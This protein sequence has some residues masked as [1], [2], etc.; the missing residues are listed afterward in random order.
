MPAAL[1]HPRFFS[2]SRAEP[3]RRGRLPDMTAQKPE[4][5]QPDHAPDGPA[6]HPV[7]RSNPAPGFRSSRNRL[8]T[9]A[10]LPDK[11][12]RGATSCCASIG[13]AGDPL[14][15]AA[16]EAA[17]ARPDSVSTDKR[18][19]L[20]RVQPWTRR[21]RRS[22]GSG[23]R[24]PGIPWSGMTTGPSAGRFD[25]RHRGRSNS[26]NGAAPRPAG[27]G[28]ARAMVMSS[29]RETMARD[30]AHPFPRGRP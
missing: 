29:D 14:G 19:C 23:T 13:S 22:A 28:N 1:A 12:R 8:P 26:D 7:A 27:K 25:G 6:H 2:H 9:R 4:P 5:D 15:R 3:P 11:A 10:M 17:L 18:A 21:T 24:I 30:R 16:F 20:S